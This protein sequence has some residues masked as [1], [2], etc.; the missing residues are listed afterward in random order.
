MHFVVH[1]FF[2]QNRLFQKKIRNTIRVSS[3]LDPDQAR[4]F[5][6]PDLGPNCL[7]RLSAEDAS[8]KRVKVKVVFGKVNVCQGTHKWLKYVLVQTNILLQGRPP[9]KIAYQKIIYHM[10]W[11]LVVK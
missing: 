11:R 5:V 6:W 4:H 9:D 8:K 2:F 10:T 1:C 7:Q 3:S